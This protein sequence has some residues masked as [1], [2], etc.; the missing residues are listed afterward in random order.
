MRSNTSSS[1]VTEGDEEL[2]RRDWEMISVNN[3]R[4]EGNEALLCSLKTKLHSQVY[5][6]G[7]H[8]FLTS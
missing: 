7:G 2:E 1:H 5:T 3:H 4:K 8:S 6:L